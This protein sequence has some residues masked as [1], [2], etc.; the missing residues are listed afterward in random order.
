MRNQARVILLAI[1]FGLC[2]PLALAPFNIWPLMFIG[3]GGYF[4]LCHESTST[5]QALLLGW[6]FG[7]GYFGLGVSWIYGSMQT[8]GT[9]VWLSLILTGGFCLALAILPALQAWFYYRFLKSLPLELPLIAPLWWILSEWVRE[10]LF[11]GMPWLFAGYAFTDLAI[12]Q[13]AALF[14]IY[15]LSA[16]FAF[17]SAWLLISLKHL[18]A[19]NTRSALGYLGA[20]LAVFAIFSAF[21]YLVPASTWTTATQSIKVSVIQS[22]IDQRLKW[23]RAQQLPTLEFYSEAI[24]ASEGVDL[25]LWPEAAMTRRPDQI[26]LFIGQVQ[27]IAAQRGQAILTGMVTHDNDRFFNAMLGYGTASGEYRKQHLVPFGEYMPF[28]KQLRGLIAIFD[29]PMSTMS[30]ALS[31]QYPITATLNGEPYFIAPVICYEATYPSLVKSLAKNSNIIAIISND[32]WFGDSIGPHQHLQIS[33]LRAIENGRDMLR[34]TQNGISAL[35]DANGTV[36]HRSEQF[37]EADV[38]GTLTLRTGLTPYQRMPSALI[39]WLALV[40]LL[41]IFGFKKIK[42]QP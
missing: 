31:P 6:A 14:G 18:N 20:S 28:E 42:T 4:W 13:T 38:R 22:N 12:G 16:L 32:A 39:P 19:R 15:G 35:V 21:G 5:K 33:R 3:I 40:I 37:V 24:K 2:A 10:W 23:T 41:C 30:P 27:D 9:P 26:P 11:T 8:V 7:A 34:A 36:T 25:M 17:I 1:L 29:I